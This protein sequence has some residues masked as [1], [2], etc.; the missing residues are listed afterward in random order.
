MEYETAAEYDV[1]AKTIIQEAATVHC[2]SFTLIFFF[3]YP[4]SVRLLLVHGVSFLALKCF[5]V[6]CFF[7]CSSGSFSTEGLGFLSSDFN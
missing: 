5:S 4:L 6:R 3:E 1:A 2:F 7:F